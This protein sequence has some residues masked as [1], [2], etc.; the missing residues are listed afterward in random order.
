MLAM[1]LRRGER[2]TPGLL[3]GA[4]LVRRFCF[5]PAAAFRARISTVR[6][7]EVGRRRVRRR[8]RATKGKGAPRACAPACPL[9]SPAVLVAH[10]PCRL[11]HD[12]WLPPSGDGRGRQVGGPPSIII[13]LLLSPPLSPLAFLG[14]VVEHLCAYAQ[15]SRRT[16]PRP[17]TFSLCARGALM[18]PGCQG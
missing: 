18:A 7:Q 10:R 5:P 15:T 2:Y 8:N 3:T 6:P 4:G 13:A 11:L 12:D 17:N 16:T 1:E 9:P 14:K